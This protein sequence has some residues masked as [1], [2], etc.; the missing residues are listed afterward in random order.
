MSKHPKEGDMVRC[1]TNKSGWSNGQVTKIENQRFWVAT[2]GDGLHW[3]YLSDVSGSRLL[4]P[5]SPLEALA[6]Q[7]NANQ[8]P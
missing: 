8:E 4:Q 7:S 6:E 5:L 3:Y 1:W 2:E